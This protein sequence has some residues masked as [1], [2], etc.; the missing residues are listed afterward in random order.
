MF[1]LRTCL[2]M[3]I[4]AY[5]LH[6]SASTQDDVRVRGESVDLAMLDQLATDNP[7]AHRIIVDGTYDTMAPTERIAFVHEIVRDSVADGVRGERLKALTDEL[8]DTVELVRDRVSPQHRRQLDDLINR[9]M[10]RRIHGHARYIQMR[11][12]SAEGDGEALPAY[13]KQLVEESTELREE[14][15]E[16]VK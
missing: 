8:I 12:R 2:P 5:A 14:F 3:L 15:R 9:I 10:K 11:R 4:G 1:H 13:F 7:E 16:A 6:S